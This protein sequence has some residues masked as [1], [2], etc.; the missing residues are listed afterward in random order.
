MPNMEMVIKGLDCCLGSNDCD[1]ERKEDC[2]YKG[3]Y[4]CAMLLRCDILALLKA[5]EEKP[6]RCDKCSYHREDGW[7]GMHGRWVKETDYCSLGAWEGR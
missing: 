4:L 3:M 5:Q 2:P 6:L 1:I 7:C